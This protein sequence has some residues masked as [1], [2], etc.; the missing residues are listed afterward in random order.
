MYLQRTIG[1]Q[2]VQGLFKSGAI[3]TNQKEGKPSDNSEQKADRVARGVV[4]ETKA[5]ASQNIYRQEGEDEE[6][7]MMPEFQQRE[8]PEEEALLQGKF[9][10]AQSQSGEED[11]LLQG[12]FTNFQ[13]QKTPEDEEELQMKASPGNLQRQEEEEE[14][15]LQGKFTTSET[16]VQ[17][18]GNG[19]MAESHT[20]MPRPLK[21][22]LESLSGI[23][24]SGV[25][26]HKNSSKPGQINALAYTQ[27]QEIHASQGQEKHLPHEGWHAV[28]QMQGRVRQRC[29]QREY[30]L[31][32]M[33]AWSEKRM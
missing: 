11:E 19:D 5:T 10:S 9:E 13:R 16:A 25:R 29:R 1:N 28:Q 23:D 15:L 7:Q 24:L 21:A 20:G 2:A 14:E 12:K 31:M 32:M 3:Q 27:G 33:W 17:L 30:R 6:A 26:V 18:K 4:E 8:T 22:G